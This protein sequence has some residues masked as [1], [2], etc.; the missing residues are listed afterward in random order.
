MAGV[1]TLLVRDL[2]VFLAAPIQSLYS[3][4]FSNHRGGKT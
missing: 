4:I 2:F 1:D 3:S